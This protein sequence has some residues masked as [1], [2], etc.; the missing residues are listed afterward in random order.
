MHKRKLAIPIE[1]TSE[2][3]ARPT[4]EKDFA[5]L[6]VG[7]GFGDTE[8]ERVILRLKISLD[9]GKLTESGPP[10]ETTLTNPGWLTTARSHSDTIYVA[11]E[12]DPGM[13]Q[14]YRVGIDGTLVQLGTAASSVG[15]NPCYTALDRSGQWL[16]AA[17][18]TEGSVSVVRINADGSLGPAT[19]SKKHQEGAHC[20]A[21]VPHPTNQWLAVCDLGLSAVFI[22]AFDV[23][24]GAI[25]G[26]ADD[27]RHLRLAAGAG[28]RHACWSKDG[29]FLF[30]NNEL[31][32][33]VTS[34]SFDV[35]SGALAEV[36]TVPALPQS[37][38]P[39]RSGHRGGS[40]LQ[41]HPNGRC[42]FVGCRSGPVGLVASFKVDPKAG[43]LSLVAH[44]STRGDVPRNFKLVGKHA[45]WLVVG[46]QESKS[47]V[48]FAVD[49]ETGK[50]AFADQLHTFH[51]P[52]NIAG[53]STH[54][55]WAD[56]ARAATTAA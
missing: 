40:D 2:K 39:D 46:N 27:P 4:V 8:P 23:R 10:I 9:D 15:R 53:P 35:T 33:T 47:V 18:Y 30:I 13:L 32:C 16:F 45:D 6:H 11:F 38:T 43:T 22:Y 52:C 28:C 25:I 49:S 12:V 19:D 44:E 21:I 48:S 3:V 20:H 24:R 37:V 36:Q 14:A 7:T 42:L 54:T 17:N 41:L 50:L 56:A 51:K 26:A 5:L 55:I 31:D 1:Q 34:A 29:K